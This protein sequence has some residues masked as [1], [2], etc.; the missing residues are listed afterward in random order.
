MIHSQSQLFSPRRR[1]LQQQSSSV[2]SR[3]RSRHRPRFDLLEER[4]LLSSFV[5]SNT[6][7]SGPGSLRQAI[8]DANSQGGAETITFD[9]TAFASAQTITLTSGQLELSDTTG[10]ETITGPAAGVTVSGGGNSRVFQVDTGVTASIS[11]LTITGG[12][13]TGQHG[14]GVYNVGGNLTLNNVTISGN[15][16]GSSGGGGLGVYNGTTTLTNCTV[17]GN[18]SVGKGGG[19]GVY[20]GTTSLTNCTLYGNSATGGLG[21]G[22]GLWAKGTTTVTDCTVSGNIASETGGGIQVGNG[23]TMTIGNTIVAGNNAPNGPDA[24]QV[25]G[26]FVSAGNN[27]IGD[28]NGSSGW[29]SSDLTGTIAAPLNPLLAPLGEYGGPTQTMA[30]LP[31]SPAI[32]A[33]DNALIPASVT[34]DQRGSDRVVNGTVDIGAFESSGFT[35]AVTSGGGQTASGAFPAPLVAT[36]TA[37]NPIEPVAGGQ[38]GFTAPQTGASA[39]IKGSPA[40]ISPIGQAS[41]TAQANSIPGSYTVSATAIGVAGAAS[42]SLRTEPASS[43]TVTNTLDDGSVGSL[44]WAVEQ[45][46]AGGGAETIDFDPSLFNTPQTITLTSGELELSNT[47]GT[48]TITGPAAGVTFSAGGTSRV[49]QVDA[50]VTASI[51]GMTITGGSAGNGGGLYNDGGTITLNDCT[52]SSNSAG[53]GGGLYDKG[54]S[55]ILTD[56]NVSDNSAGSFGGGVFSSGP[57]ATLTNCTLASNTAGESGGAIELQGDATLI[58]C[59][60]SGNQAVYGG[61]IDNYWGRYAVTVGNSIIAG[62]TGYLPDFSGAVVLSAITSSA[63]P[64]APAAGSPPT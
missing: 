43:I 62:N 47:T 41:V 18:K 4:T 54:G 28:T 51:S 23:G 42:F 13:V 36:V 10:T 52:I 63:I 22:G 26:V 31:G 17:S 60:L 33:G 20:S 21:Y 55:L 48:E 61:A 34:T 30:L 19:L 59:T 40:T 24:Y 25:T 64:S 37:N 35:I 45:A 12:S 7:D 14:G 53:S 57:P 16:D 49:F 5:V 44:R 11:G 3:I 46:N 38:V 1:G 27:L 15:Y 58:N 56:C 29:A 32:D 50:N 9:P 6:G 39:I 8:L 2:S